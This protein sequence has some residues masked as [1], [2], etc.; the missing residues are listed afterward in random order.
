MITARDFHVLHQAETITF[1]CVMNA[2]FL[3][4]FQQLGKMLFDQAWVLDNGIAKRPG[5]SLVHSMV[6][7][8]EYVKKLVKSFLGMTD[9]IHDGITVGP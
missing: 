1:D 5:C 9:P 6:P 3:E 2:G 7:A 8:K 4:I